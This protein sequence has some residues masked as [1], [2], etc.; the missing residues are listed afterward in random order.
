MKENKYKFERLTPV[1]DIDLNVYEEAIDYVFD[2][3]DIKNVAISGAY[4]AGKSS[5]LASYKKKHSNL[6]FL[7]ISLAHF[8]PFDQEDETEISES[9]LEGKIL[10]QLIHQIPSDKIPQTN[11]RVKKRISPKSVIERTVGVILLL[12]SIIYFT[13]FDTW[14]KYVVTLP[15][16]W[17]KS[18]LSLSTHQYALIA[19]GLLIA[20]LLFYAVYS[21]INVQKNKNVFRKLNLQGNEIE[22]FEESDDSYFDKYL[23]E[24]LYLFEN[25]EADVIVFEDMDRFNANKVFERLREVNTLANIQ[26]QKEDKKVLRFFYLLRDDIFVS[27]DRTKFFDYIVP[28][29]PVVDSS[30]SYDQFISHFKNGGIFEKFDVNFLQGLSLYIDDMRILKNIYNEFIIY[31]NRLNITE[32]DCNKM[33]AIIAYKNLFPRDFAEL[34]LNQGF[35]YTLFYS[36]DRFIA[37]EIQTLN[38]R[39]SKKDHEIELAKNE[40]LKSIAELDVVFD[41]KRP[42]NY[43]GRRPDL[44]Q[45]DQNEYSERKKAIE[46]KLSD[47][48]PVIENEKLLLEE[49]IVS[50]Q[51]EQLSEIITRDNI[52]SIFGIK[53]ENEIGKVTE[54]NEIK[55]SEYFDLLKYLIRNG[56][57]DETYADYMTY[58]YENSLSRIDKTFLRSITDKKAKEYNYK[59]KN[60]QLVVSR[61]RLVDFDQEET[62]NYDLFTY[63]LV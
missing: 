29:V 3:S 26:L 9:V 27:K 56:Y 36:K 25:A 28:I 58:F 10:N 54:F 49:K 44:S 4:S 46:D 37:K 35:V 15:N 48:I 57:I 43:Y 32:L 23:N 34:Q 62:L 22:I 5:V 50:I 39:I 24:V 20:G 63:L 53:S 41:N 38:E 42:T 18:I 45:E 40:H 2:N 11:F 61:L 52:D 31:Y 51:N 17:F 1:D 14:E 55:S 47:K 21:F 19:D 59:L 12:M 16:N 30:N 33:F 13:C 60:P 6:C 7:H 8:R